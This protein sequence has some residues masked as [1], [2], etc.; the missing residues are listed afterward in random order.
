MVGVWGE[1]RAGEDGEAA[2]VQAPGE[3]V[4]WGWDLRLFQFG[5]AARFGVVWAVMVCSPR[6][7]PEVVLGFLRGERRLQGFSRWRT[8]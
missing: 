4:V 2:P 1:G 6:E 7:V 5:G 8:G 3:G